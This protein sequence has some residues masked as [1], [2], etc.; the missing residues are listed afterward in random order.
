VWDK[1]NFVL[2]EEQQMS[3]ILP[4]STIG[5]LGGGQLGRMSTFKARQLGYNVVVL[6]PTPNS[7]CGQVADEQ[8]VAGFDDEAALRQ[9]AGKCDVITYEFENV[10]AQAV[11]LLENSG[12]KVYPDCR[13]LRISQNR[14]SEK[15]FLR[16]NGIG[17]ADFYKVTTPADLEV[18][19][20]Q[21]GF[22]SLLKTAAGGYDGKGQFV[23]DPGNDNGEIARA[24]FEQSQPAAWIWE[25]KVPFAKELS[26][27]C[28]RNQ[29]GEVVTY[30]ATE[31][32]HVDNI[33]DISLTPAAVSPRVQANAKQIAHI[34]AEKLN[35]VGVCGVEMFLL[36]DETILVNELAPRPHNSGH[37]TIDACI[38][39]QFEQH[40]RAICGLPLGSTDLESYAAMVNILGT[41]TGNHLVGLEN[42]LQNDRICFHLYGKKEAAARRKMGHLTALSGQSTG[43]ALRLALE[44]RAKLKWT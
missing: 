29:A 13:V 10:D 33:L 43:E 4:G 24:I 1:L 11:E 35:L 30:P 26:V 17:V 15:E 44:A 6:D 19:A 12:K 32:V 2:P 5:M 21:I 8:I 28:A 42:V 3:V 27:I 37:Y 38:C 20:R 16:Q 41:G 23:I 18:A 14:W 31:N 34:I 7:P 22:P 9:L 36:P 25:K 40:I 39:S